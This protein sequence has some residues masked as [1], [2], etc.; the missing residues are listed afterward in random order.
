MYRT[1]VACVV[2]AAVTAAITTE[3]SSGSGAS[4]PGVKTI[5]VGQTA[6]F[7]HQDLICVNESSSGAPRRFKT[8]GAA[9][10]SYAK[11]YTGVGLWL[12]RGRIVLTRPPNAKIVSSYRR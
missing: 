5:Y 1:L 8:A 7:A 10:S 6:I 12:T 11:P 4:S 2:T 3:L 9:C